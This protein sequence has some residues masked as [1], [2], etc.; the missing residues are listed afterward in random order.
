MTNIVEF[1]KNQALKATNPDEFALRT[2]GLK[3]QEGNWTEDARVIVADLKSVQLGYK[4]HEEFIK[5]T[6]FG[7]TLSLSAF[8]LHALFIEFAADLLKIA[9]EKIASEKSK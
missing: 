8:E 6:M 5:K 7:N 9:N 4:D 2:A 3:D 1:V